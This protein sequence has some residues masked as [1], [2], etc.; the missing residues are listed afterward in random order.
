MT[1]DNHD[2]DER[3]EREMSEQDDPTLTA[4]VNRP[5]SE[6]ESTPLETA[7]A[8]PAAASTLTAPIASGRIRV[9]PS[10]NWAMESPR[11]AAVRYQERAWPRS[12]SPKAPE[13]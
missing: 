4:R 1:P 9:S 11:S 12:A 5:G 3:S 8:E 7:P 6:E 13:S 10:L 2:R